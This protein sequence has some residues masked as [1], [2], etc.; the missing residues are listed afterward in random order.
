MHGPPGCKNMGR[1]SVHMLCKIKNTI[2]ML[3]QGNS[4]KDGSGGGAT[5]L[6]SGAE[7]PKFA[8]LVGASDRGVDLH[9]LS[10]VMA[11]RVST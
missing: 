2:A 6:T 11:I 7:S 8:R 10:S 1:Q 3:Y 9:K 5:D 4:Y